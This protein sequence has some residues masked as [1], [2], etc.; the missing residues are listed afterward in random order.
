VSAFQLDQVLFTLSARQRQSLVVE[1][2][3]D[4]AVDLGEIETVAGRVRAAT[5]SKTVLT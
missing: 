4:G 3:A 5:W 2:G 1:W